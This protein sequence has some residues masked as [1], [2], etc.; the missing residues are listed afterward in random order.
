[1]EITKKGLPLTKQESIFKLFIPLE[2]KKKIEIVC[3]KIND[4]EWSGV[5]FT[6]HSGSFENKDLIIRVEDFYL[7]DIG[8]TGYTE[9]NMK[10]EVS[11]YMLENDLLHC[12]LGL[13]HSHNHMNTF[14][15][16]T[17]TSTLQEM[18]SSMNCFVSLI[19]NNA[20]V[21]TAAVTRRTKHT[22][23]IKDCYS[24][25]MFGDG[26]KRNCD[27]SEEAS[28]EIEYFM[29]EVVKEGIKEEGFGEI[30]DRIQEIE[31]EKKRIKEEEEAKKLKYPS[32]L[33]DGG[34]Y[35]RIEKEESHTDMTDSLLY[36][37]LFDY[38]DSVRIPEKQFEDDDLAPEIKIAIKILLTGN[39]VGNTTAS[40]YN[41]KEL[42]KNANSRFKSSF[43]SIDAFEFYMDNL[44]SYI[45]EFVLTSDAVIQRYQRA[46]AKDFDYPESLLADD[47]VKYITNESIVSIYEQL[48]KVEDK[49]PNYFI[50]TIKRLLLNYY[51]DQ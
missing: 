49:D 51:N 1:M 43:S 50:E 17:D 41:L 42:V 46:Y 33:F 19:V 39:P 28:E 26:E 30:Y 18:G 47:P 44:I 12:D 37:S 20:G 45:I 35:S 24:Y 15:S 22:M 8:T 27:T 4:I 14:F 34:S 36:P 23:Q 38:P 10:P 7:M 25:E 21:Y 9:F 16:G 31:R 5:L 3:D 2:V 11:T 29:L 48:Q 32:T 40:N 13:I 6:T